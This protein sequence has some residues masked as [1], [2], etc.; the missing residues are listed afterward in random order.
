M[1]EFETSGANRRILEDN[2]PFYANRASDFFLRIHTLDILR[3]F[4][5]FESVRIALD[6]SGCHVLRWSTAVP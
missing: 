6:H 4:D 3:F 1:D 2:V 5:E